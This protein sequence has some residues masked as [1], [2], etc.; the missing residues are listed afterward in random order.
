MSK[1]AVRLFRDKIGQDEQL[2]SILRVAFETMDDQ[3][4]LVDLAREY[5]FEFTEEEG[6]AALQEAREGGELSDFELELVT[7]GG[8][9]NCGGDGSKQMMT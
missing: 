7:A 5:G 4:N 1:E 6:L 9:V 8:P 3:L 2:Q